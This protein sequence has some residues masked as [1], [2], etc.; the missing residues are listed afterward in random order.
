ML[1]GV[2]IELVD[3]SNWDLKIPQELNHV[4]QGVAPLY[5]MRLE[6]NSDWSDA[7]MSDIPEETHL[8]VHS[9]NVELSDCAASEIEMYGGKLVVIH[10]EVG[11]IAA[12]DTQGIFILQ[13][14]FVE[15]FNVLQGS[16]LLVKVESDSSIGQVA[17]MSNRSHNSGPDLTLIGASDLRLWKAPI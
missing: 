15:C 16:E 2:D 4:S 12:Y 6:I 5:P 17:K 9:T 8:V 13:K 1:N 10:G 14:S 3:G 7:K 11:S